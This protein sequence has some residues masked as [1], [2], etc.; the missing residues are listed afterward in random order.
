M[1]N[2]NELNEN[3][4]LNV[5][6]GAGGLIY[7]H[8]FQKGDCLS[9]LAMRYGTTVEKICEMNNIKNPDSITVGSKLLIPCNR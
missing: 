8:V 4:L 6:G 7:V 5:S 2:F 1:T 3:D 9:A